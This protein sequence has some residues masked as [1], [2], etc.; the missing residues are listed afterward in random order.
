MTTADTTIMLKRLKHSGRTLPRTK[1]L[2]P[3]EG[4]PLARI[5]HNMEI[6][7]F[8]TVKTEAE[9]E[10]YKKTY[11]Q[12]QSQRDSRRIYNDR[13]SKRSFYI[14]WLILSIVTVALFLSITN[15][16]WWP[17]KATITLFFVGSIFLI[18][19]GICSVF[20]FR[21]EIEEYCRTLTE[22]KFYQKNRYEN[23]MLITRWKAISLDYFHREIPTQD[24]T[25]TERLVK[26]NPQ[27]KIE[28]ICFDTDPYL[29]AKLGNE[30]YYFAHF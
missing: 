24:R 3:F 30:V 16:L 13:P 5:F 6:P 4:K 7:T 9:M 14:L 27:I 21:L 26:A 17:P 11:C 23:L 1:H 8:D 15:L 12:E 25:N 2:D 29:R 28:A 18:L 10:M 20:L 22:V 19:S